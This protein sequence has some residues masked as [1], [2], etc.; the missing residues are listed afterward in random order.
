MRQHKTHPVIFTRKFSRTTVI[1]YVCV[2]AALGLILG[3][4][5]LFWGLIHGVGNV[6]PPVGSIAHVRKMHTTL[7][8][9]FT[10]EGVDQDQTNT[11]NDQNRPGVGVDFAA[12]F[13]G[14]RPRLLFQTAT[15]TMGQ[16]HGLQKAMDCK[17]TTSGHGLFSFLD[18]PAPKSI[19]EMFRS[20]R[21]VSMSFSSTKT[22][23]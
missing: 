4:S 5:P 9:Q 17:G 21:K 12:M 23:S 16:F 20:S 10:M 7:G 8:R 15:Y 13:P 19:R 1:V 2:A 6:E 3:S 14:R 11:N 22:S 18:R